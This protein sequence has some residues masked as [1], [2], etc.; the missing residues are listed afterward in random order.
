MAIAMLVSGV[1]SASNLAEAAPTSGFVTIVFDDGTS[2]QFSNAFPLMQ[3]HGFAGT[4][5]IITNNV[6]AAGY[7][8]MAN[9][10]TLQNG[11]NEIAS[12]SV[13]HQ[14]LVGL[15]DA[16]INDECKASQQFLQTNGFSALNFAYPYGS[17][18]SHT[19]SIVL[20]YFR[21]ARHAYGEGYLMSIPPTAT[22][23]RIPMGFA[24]ETGN[25]SALV[26]DEAIVAQAHSTNS[27]VI[28]FFHNILTTPLTSKFQIGQSDFAAFLNYVGN[29]SVRVL[30]M[31]QAIN[32]WSPP[33]GVTVSPSSFALDVGQSGTFTASVDGG[34]SPY[35]YKWYLGGQVIG[36]NSANYKFDASSVGSFLLYVNVTDS[37]GSLVIAKSNI[38]LIEVD[39][40]LLAPTVLASKS[41][42]DQGQNSSLTSSP[43][44]TGTSPYSYQWFEMSPGGSYVTAGS[45]SDSLGFITSS[46]TP[47]GGW[48]FILQ[49]KDNSGVAVNSSAISVTVNP[50]IS[51]SASAGGFISPTGSVAVNFGD[52][53]TFNVTADTGY[54][55][56]DVNVDGSS[57]GAVSAYTFNNVQVSHTISATFAPTPTPAPTATPTATPTPAPTDS[58]TPNPTA[59]PPTTQAPTSTLRTTASPTPTPTTKPTDTPTP[60]PKSTPTQTPTT[61]PKQTQLNLPQEAIYG[62]TSAFA[63]VATGG[64]LFASKKNKKW[65]K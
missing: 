65:K 36:V 53:Q 61:S 48:S 20:Q 56:V 17:A 24:G 51:A 40:A 44:T 34:L 15:T 25:S 45:N 31:N 55:I 57:V 29:S 35:K 64:V 27:W 30:T 14:S 50:T 10:Q 13:D 7:M 52:S 11:G 12:H 26:Q 58:P 54:D 46:A 33:L 8:N 59:T 41:V 4:Y 62:V 23:M 19:D 32:L 6:G 47:A 28:I 9:L 22:Q 37:S 60:T 18:N 39:F 16:K 2:N 21:S 1:F 42:V 3:Q 63:I 49:V 43:I 38:A 5:Y